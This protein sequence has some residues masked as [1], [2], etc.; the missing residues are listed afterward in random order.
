MERMKSK[1]KAF[2]EAIQLCGSQRKLANK[3]NVAQQT[4]NKWARGISQVPI[5]RAIQLEKI[6]DGNSYIKKEFIRPDVDW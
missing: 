3:L 4:V 5:A 1:N 6:F 2:E